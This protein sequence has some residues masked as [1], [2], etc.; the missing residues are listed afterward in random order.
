[1]EVLLPLLL[2]LPAAAV[3]MIALALGASVLV[4]ACM[5]MMAYALSNPQM[6]AMAREELAALIFSVFIIVFWVG[7]DSLL[8]SISNGILVSSLPPS[9]QGFAGSSTMG[10]MTN[11]H[12]QLA[13]ATL[14][15]LEQK[16]KSQYIDLYL[17]EALIG[18]LSTISF[19]LGSPLPAVNVISFSLSPFAGLNLLSNAHTVIVEAIG[20]LISVV[21][22][23]EFILI[24]ARDTIPILL[25]PIGLVLRA[26]PFFRR[27]G[28]SVIAICFAMYF[29]LP[30][31][32]ILSNYLI[33]DMFDP[34]DFAYTPSS[35]SYF[36]TDRT[37]AETQS[38]V[39]QGRGGSESNEILGQFMA[40]SVVDAS[41]SHATDACAGNAIVRLLCSVKNIVT[42]AINVVGGF[43][44]TVWNIWRFMVGMTG[45]FFFTGF[46]NPLMPSSASAGLYFFI[47]KEVS[48]ISPFI[49][50]VMLTTVIEII[51]TVTGYRSLSLLIGGE[52][53]I[54]GLTKVI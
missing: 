12:L 4:V 42:G 31:S 6:V 44:K 34:P 23:K 38:S 14:T 26:I 8:N 51:I 43:L 27:T 45:D 47:I 40:P 25:F 16:L 46:N 11:S 2:T 41:S 10:G 32:M 3:S 15:L 29:V 18:F 37:A 13:L 30:F 28:S 20:Y 24:F 21:W 49:I 54:T 1:M 17:F 22:A 39:E 52:A 33:F 53:E 5:F 7:S 19:P 36:G 50:L 35:A 48:I 9:L